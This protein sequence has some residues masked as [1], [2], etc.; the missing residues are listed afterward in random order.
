MPKLNTPLPEKS[1][2]RIV[3]LNNHECLRPLSATEEKINQLI[4]VVAE[5]TE[6]VEGQYKAGYMQGKFDAEIDLNPYD[7]KVS[8]CSTPS[9]KEQLLE[10]VKLKQYTPW[11]HRNDTEG[12]ITVVKLSDIEAII[13]RLMP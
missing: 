7:V 5:L 4:D 9:L 8:P 6:V 2:A 3:I 11:D 13:N 1:K 12:E 10:Q